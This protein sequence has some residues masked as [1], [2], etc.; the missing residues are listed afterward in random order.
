ME[1]ISNFLANSSGLYLTLAIIGSIVFIIQAIL[2][3]TGLGDSHDLDADISIGDDAMDIA[4]GWDG[5]HLFTFRGIV[6]FITFFGW[7]GYLWGDKG[8]AGFMIAVFAGVFMMVLTAFV[9]WGL[10]KLQHSGNIPTESLVNRH[11]V[12]YLSIPEGKTGKGKVTVSLPKCTRT[13]NAISETALK[14]GMPVKVTELLD[15]NIFVVEPL[16]K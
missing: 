13:V 9:V 7:A 10:L 14:T 12:V 1:Q 2:T 15:G 11:G 5:L 16:E 3:L 6:A 4:G 8:L